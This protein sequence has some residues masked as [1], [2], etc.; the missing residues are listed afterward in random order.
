MG[1]NCKS[2]IWIGTL[3]RFLP[4][5]VD[6]QSISDYELTKCSIRNTWCSPRRLISVTNGLKKNYLTPLSNFHPM[7][8]VHNW[9]FNFIDW[10]W[11]RAGTQF[12]QHEIRRRNNVKYILLEIPGASCTF[13]GLIQGYLTIH[14]IMSMYI[15]IY[16]R[17]VSLQSTCD[18]EFVKTTKSWFGCL[19][20]SLSRYHWAWSW[21]WLQ[22]KIRMMF[23]VSKHFVFF[24][25]SL[26]WVIWN[27][28]WNYVWL[29]LNCKKKS[30]NSCFEKKKNPKFVSS[31]FIITFFHDETKIIFDLK[32]INEKSSM[33]T[34]GNCSCFDEWSVSRSS[35][36]GSHATSQ[37][38]IQLLIHIVTSC[39]RFQQ[40]DTRE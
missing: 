37:T 2:S 39:V 25:W 6:F 12:Q 1:G 11:S 7:K 8:R 31:K 21:D 36:R 5:H 16:A 26:S 23:D 10:K 24:C 18:R 33:F 38:W 30:P 27:R 17:V 4:C 32:N 34:V 15:S 19:I 35:D 9:L 13:R 14:I 20:R 3:Y 29:C 22:K 28:A 40:R